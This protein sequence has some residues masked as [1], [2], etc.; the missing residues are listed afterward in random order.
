MLR[1]EHST[2][3][4][5]KQPCNALLWPRS[6]HFDMDEQPCYKLQAPESS[7][8]GRETCRK[9]TGR[10]LREEH[11]T[12][13]MNNYARTYFDIDEQSCYKLQV[14]AGGRGTCRK[15]AGS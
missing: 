9:R 6:K 2:V 3:S 14:P 15:R 5:S 13:S 10:M 12:V 11:S 4:M 1:K 7:A 8:G